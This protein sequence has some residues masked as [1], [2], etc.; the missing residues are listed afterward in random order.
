MKPPLDDLP[1]L[2][3]QWFAFSAKC[4]NFRE[5]IRFAQRLSAVNVWRRAIIL[6][7]DCGEGCVPM[8]VDWRNIVDMRLGELVP[9]RTRIAD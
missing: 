6:E 9:E 8:P 1:D 5:P 2:I 4:P 3:G 7:F